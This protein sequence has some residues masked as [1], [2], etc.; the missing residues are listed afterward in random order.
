VAF[1]TASGATLLEAYPADPG[2]GRIPAASAYHGTLS[3]FEKAGFEVVARRQFNRTTPVRPIV[4][5][6]IP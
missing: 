6:A 1:A 2:E 5:R 4:R 3:M